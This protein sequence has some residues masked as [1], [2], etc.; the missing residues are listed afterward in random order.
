MP[1]NHTPLISALVGGAAI[2][3]DVDAWSGPD[4]TVIDPSLPLNI[5]GASQSLPGIGVLTLHPTNTRAVVFTPASSGG[6]GSNSFNVGTTPSADDP[7]SIDVSV[8]PP[9]VK[10]RV[11]YKSHGPVQP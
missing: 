1:I 2:Q 7:L 11:T 6:G 10:R 3:I 8:S 9:P 5:G 4:G